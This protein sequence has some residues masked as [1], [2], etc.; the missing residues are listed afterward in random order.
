MKDLSPTVYVNQGHD[1]VCLLITLD[2]KNDFTKKTEN[3]VKLAVCVYQIVTKNT[4][5][6]GLS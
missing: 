4:K 3:F 5:L 1:D 2:K 6:Y